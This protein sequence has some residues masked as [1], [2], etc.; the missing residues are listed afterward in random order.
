[1]QGDVPAGAD[2]ALDDLHVAGCRH[3]DVRRGTESRRRRGTWQ[4]GAR[5][6]TDVQ[7]A[8]VD[9]VDA[10]RARRGLEAPD[11][12]LDV[13]AGQADARRRVHQHVRCEVDVDRVDRI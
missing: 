2:D 10:A 12:R 8:E 13:V 9:D 3:A 6:A 7:A 4:R 11:V 1:M 5:D